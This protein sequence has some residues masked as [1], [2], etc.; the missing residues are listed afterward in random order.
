[1]FKDIHVEG[2]GGTIEVS[3]GPRSYLVWIE[4]LVDSSIIE[5]EREKV[6]DLIKALKE[7]SADE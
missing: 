2:S 6:P 3:G 4:D 1:M 5:I 7:V